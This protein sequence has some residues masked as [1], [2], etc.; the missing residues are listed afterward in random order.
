[1]PFQKGNKLAKK[2]DDEKLS[3]FLHCR[4]HPLDK[5]NWVRQAQIENKKLCTWVTEK[6]NKEVK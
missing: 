1:M 5:S 6:L 3:S 2:P 4:V